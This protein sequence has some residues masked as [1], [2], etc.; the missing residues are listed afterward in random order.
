VAS[1]SASCSIPFKRS[2]IVAQAQPNQPRAHNCPH[3]D[4]LRDVHHV[5]NGEG[6]QIITV[7]QL[8]HQLPVKTLNVD[9]AH[10]YFMVGVLEVGFDR[11]VRYC[12][13]LLA[14]R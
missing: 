8:G 6:M 1:P 12:E 7:R 11:F 2:K 5:L 9:P 3:L 4:A 13:S 10:L 14:C